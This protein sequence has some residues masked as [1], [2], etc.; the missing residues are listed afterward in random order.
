MAPL[1]LSSGAT[2]PA[3][4]VS[5]PASASTCDKCPD[6][7]GGGDP[8][9]V[10]V[11]CACSAG[12]KS[13]ECEMNCSGQI[14]AGPWIKCNTLSTADV[15]GNA[16]CTSEVEYCALGNVEGCPDK[17]DSE[18]KDAAKCLCEGE[19]KCDSFILKDATS[20]ASGS[21]TASAV[22]TFLVAIAYLSL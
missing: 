19:D 8:F 16:M 7:A 10:T 17:Y 5:S 22:F 18:N 6:S 4:I 12:K 15:C 1:R 14:V 21:S 11:T 20:A 3:D 9:A 2:L 13:I